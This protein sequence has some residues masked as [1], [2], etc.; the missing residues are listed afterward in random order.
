MKKNKKLKKTNKYKEEVI[1]R[2]LFEPK[3][4]G[5]ISFI[6]V[7]SLISPIQ[8][9]YTQKI[10]PVVDANNQINCALKKGYPSFIVYEEEAQIIANL[11]RQLPSS[12]PF[13]CHIPPYG[14]KFH[15]DNGNVI[16]IE[17]CWQCHS[18]QVWFSDVKN[19]E[20]AFSFD[21]DSEPAQKL[22]KL[23]HNTIPFK[24]K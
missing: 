11:F 3:T 1:S 15:L 18:G 2:V 7:V 5:N 12:V 23:C 4:I 10:S 22:F 16:Y 17:L 13:R 9:I 24:S 6:E 21:A 14:F 8:E 19:C 20:T